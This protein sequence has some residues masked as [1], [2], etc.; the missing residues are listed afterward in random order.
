M[1]MPNPST[2]CRT[3]ARQSPHLADGAHR[4]GR[5]TRCDGASDRAGDHRPRWGPR[6]VAVGYLV[7][8][9]AGTVGFH[10]YFTHGSFKTTRWLRIVLA[11]A[12][13]LAIEGSVPA[14]A[15]SR[16]TVRF[17]SARCCSTSGERG[18]LECGR[19]RWRIRGRRPPSTPRSPRVR[20]IGQLERAL[21]R[22][23]DEVEVAGT[24]RGTGRERPGSQIPRRHRGRLSAGSCRP[25]RR[26]VP[27]GAHRRL[28]AGRRQLIPAALATVDRDEQIVAVTRRT[29]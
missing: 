13:S 4:D 25:G 2:P 16:L 29:H 27:S 12:G 15:S 21:G 6:V 26:S 1:S 24:S 9:F 17:R 14:Q 22:K 8:G 7:S 5:I 28:A 23:T 18:L 3:P 10:R 19:P 20:A 11:I